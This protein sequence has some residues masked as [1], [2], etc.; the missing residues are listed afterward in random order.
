MGW[1]EASAVCTPKTLIKYDLGPIE[2]V[3]TDRI[4]KKRMS[5]RAAPWIS[6]PFPEAGARASKMYAR[7]SEPGAALLQ[8]P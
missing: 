7:T 5:C 3:R 4:S 2:G 6:R 1:F 8:M